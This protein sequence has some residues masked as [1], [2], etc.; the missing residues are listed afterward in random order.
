M[1]LEEKNCQTDGEKVQTYQNTGI[2]VSLINEII[3]LA[4][5]YHVE[6]VILFGSRARGDCFV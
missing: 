2:K 4:E 3:G 5:K 1:N 6:K